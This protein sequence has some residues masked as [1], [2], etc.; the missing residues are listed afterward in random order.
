MCVAKARR[1]V[2]AV[3]PKKMIRVEGKTIVTSA[4]NAGSSAVVSA[5]GE[6]FVFGKDTFHC[7]NTSGMSLCLSVSVSLSLCVC[8]SVCL[9]VSVYVS[10][11][12]CLCVSLCLS[13]SV[14]VSLCV[15]DCACVFL[16]LCVYMCFLRM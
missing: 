4:C 5:D 10:L 9:S 12:L 15:C 2:K 6:V 7:D 13:V 14:C 3:K 11:C 8:L 1:Q 16:C